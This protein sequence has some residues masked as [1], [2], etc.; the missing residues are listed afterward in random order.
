MACSVASD[1]AERL[2]F[3]AN[4]VLDGRR[5]RVLVER[6]EHISKSVNCSVR[7]GRSALL[8]MQTKTLSGAYN[9]QR[10]LKIRSLFSQYCVVALRIIDIIEQSINVSVGRNLGIGNKG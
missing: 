7:N 5:K 6:V 9:K 3:D 8:D 2:R 1:T 4:M 10:L